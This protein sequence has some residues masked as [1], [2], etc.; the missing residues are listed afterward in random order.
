M[1]SQVGQQAKWFT[2]VHARVELPLAVLGKEVFLDLRA[3][4][5]N[6]PAESAE[7]GLLLGVA[8]TGLPDLPLVEPT[9]NGAGVD[10]LGIL[11][12]L[13]LR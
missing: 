5:T 3:A 7:K 8:A 13:V 12:R 10:L 6:E 1:R 4:G 2:A 11:L 9:P